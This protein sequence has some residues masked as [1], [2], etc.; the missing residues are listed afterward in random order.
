MSW[1][2]KFR[3]QLL[4]EVIG[5]ESIVARLKDFVKARNFPNMIFTGPAGVGKTTCAMAM[6]REL[7]GNR[8]SESFLE[9]NASDSRGIDVENHKKEAYP[10]IVKIMYL[11]ACVK[12]IRH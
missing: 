5:Q 10:E 7:Y 11:Y 1:A 3:P 2:E 9:L 4:D 8:T 12:A 6:A